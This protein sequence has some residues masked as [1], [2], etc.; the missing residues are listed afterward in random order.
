MPI[1]SPV[2][3]NC[4][5]ISGRGGGGNDRRK[6]FMINF[7]CMKLAVQQYGSTAVQQYTAVLPHCCTATLLYC[8]TAILLY[9][10]TAVLPTSRTY[11]FP[12]K[13]VAGT[14]IEPVPLTSHSDALPSAVR[15]TASTHTSTY[16][17]IDG[18]L[19]RIGYLRI[20]L[21]C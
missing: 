16:V 4:P 2:T 15:G 14:A 8:H 20:Q 9:C 12:R 7:I 19:Y 18:L 1:P 21:I 13:S 11:Q 3:D 5:S 6:D 10:Y 17:H